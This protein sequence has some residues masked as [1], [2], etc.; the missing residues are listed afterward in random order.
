MNL[1]RFD[2]AFHNYDR[3]DADF[4]LIYYADGVTYKN[5]GHDYSEIYSCVY[6]NV[7]RIIEFGKYLSNIRKKDLCKY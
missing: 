2:N 5:E 3:D 6:Y 1:S 7:E 4:Y